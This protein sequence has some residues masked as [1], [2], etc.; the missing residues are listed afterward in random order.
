MPKGSG[1]K[2]KK[3]LHGEDLEN[4]IKEALE[5]REPWASIC[6]RL[7]VG[8]RLIQLVRG[9]SFPEEARE[10]KNASKLEA[11]DPE[12]DDDLGDEE[13]PDDSGESDEQENLSN[14]HGEIAAKYFKLKDKH[15]H[16]H[17]ILETL[18]L[19]PKTA[20]ALDKWYYRLNFHDTAQC[21]KDY[22]RG[23]LAQ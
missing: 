11:I 18:K 12:E 2:K 9:K 3:L 8:T 14:F 5:N 20:E 7:H 4:A 10:N 13:Y 16:A 6:H 17:K 19:S 23:A 22:E 15:M 21:K 1:R